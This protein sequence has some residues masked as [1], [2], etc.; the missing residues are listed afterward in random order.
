MDHHHHA[1][2]HPTPTQLPTR[3]ALQ[4]LYVL[5]S[6]DP[7]FRPHVLHELGRAFDYGAGWKET[8]ARC[9]CGA[10]VIDRLLSL[11]HAAY[12]SDEL[13]RERLLSTIRSDDP[14]WTAVDNVDRRSNLTARAFR[15]EYEVPSRPVVITDIVPRWPAFQSWARVALLQN[16]GGTP[17]KVA[18]LEMPLGRFFQYSERNHDQRPLYL[19]D[20]AF[21]TR[22]PSMD[23]DYTLPE[24]FSDDFLRLLADPAAGTPRPD[25]RWLIIGPAGSGS[26][27]HVD[28][29]GTCAWNAVITGRKKWILYPPSIIPPGVVLDAHGGFTTPAALGAWLLDH[30]AAIADVPESERP[31]ECVCTAGDLMFVPSGW[32]HC[33]INLD[34][35]IALTH[36]VVTEVNLANAMELLA[37]PA[38]CAPGKCGGDVMGDVPLWVAMGGS[39]TVAT[40][41]D[42]NEGE[43][44]GDAAAP[45]CTCDRIKATL[46]RRLRNGIE[47][48][49]P[50]LLTR[51]ESEQAAAAAERSTLWDTMKATPETPQ[52]SFGF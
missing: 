24:Y 38:R 52:F 51:L 28:P 9:V 25:N 49:R 3:S 39:S 42:G 36:N 17:F 21:A 23:A 26:S 30:H 18:G 19:F 2:I 48:E 20:S 7:L 31:L 22:C 29:N 34:E 40:E 11:D 13:Y 35:S 5:G 15:D 50:G 33:V 41:D 16:Q 12:E 43:S 1:L 27:F 14:T 10:T 45:K 8:Y 32:W 47:L 6:W 46:L 4:A 44:A 37:E